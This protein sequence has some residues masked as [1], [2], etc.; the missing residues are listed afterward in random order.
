MGFAKIKLP[1]GMFRNGTEYEASGRWYDGNLVRWENGRLKPIGGWQALFGPSV[2]FTG[3]ARGGITFEDNSGFPY[4]AVG[5]NSNL[6]IGEGLGGSFSDVTP[7]GFVI[8]QVDSIQGAGYGAGAYGAGDY[9]TARAIA[10]IGLIA[11]TWQMDTFG[12]TIVMCCT[13]DGNIYQFDPTTGLVTIPSGSPT[14]LAVMATNEAF[15]LALGAGGDGR[16]IQ[17]A[18]IGTST[19][20]T[21]TDTN[22]A[23]DIDCTTAGRLMAGSRVGLQNLAWTNIDAHLINFIGGQ[24][25]YAPIRI[26]T[27]CG[28]VGPRAWAVAASAAGA[29]D[30][31]YWIS[32]GGFFAYNGAVLPL[33]C[34]IQDYIWANVNWTQA[35][36]IYASPN[37]RYNEVIWFFPSLNSLECDSYVVY[38][39]KDNIWYFGI[40][41]TLGVRTTYIDKGVF[42]LPLAVN[43]AG[44][45]YEHETGFLDNG[46]TRVGGVFAQSGPA[47]IDDGSKIIYSNLMLPDGSNLSSLQMTAQ[48]RFA[49]A[50]PLTVGT[51]TPMA[52]NAEGYVPVRIAGRQVALRFDATADTDWAI[53]SSRLKVA[54]GGG[55]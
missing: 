13:S 9:G 16:K 18:D 5:T 54:A 34:E 35:A 40:G 19:V 32:H 48:T 44:T 36:K 47:E 2:H 30:T 29:G 8:G 22:S 10:S 1:P 24:G 42:P 38:N 15:L 53:G 11:A 20:W 12:D 46:A 37:A 41:S 26:G 39:Y 55:R 51:P 25:I 28:L 17:W 27:A 21:P 50:G 7:P 52:P 49:P 4:V 23:G 6:Y 45:L 14:C 33:P 31:A 3:V 43:P